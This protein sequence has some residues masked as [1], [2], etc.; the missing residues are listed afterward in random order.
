MLWRL[1]THP[2]HALE[3]FGVRGVRFETKQ[4]A[5]FGEG[6]FELNVTVLLTAT[7]WSEP[8]PGVWSPWG[9][10]LPTLHSKV[11][12]HSGQGCGM[13]LSETAAVMVWESSSS[14]F[15]EQ[16]AELIRGVVAS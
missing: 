10:P 9:V 4:S 6:L 1:I 8:S 11:H 12:H 7:N 5:F 3:L 16:A 14:F 13:R 15:A 2:A